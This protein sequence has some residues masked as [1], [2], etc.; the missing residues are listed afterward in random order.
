MTF[1]YTIDDIITGVA[2]VVIGAIFL[3]KTIKA[4]LK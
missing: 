1:V 3:V 2:I 4:L